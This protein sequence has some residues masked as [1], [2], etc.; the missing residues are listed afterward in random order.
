MFSKLPKIDLPKINL[1]P[2]LSGNGLSKLGLRPKLLASIT[3]MAGLSAIATVIAVLSFNSAE[4]QFTQF[5][6]NRVPALV[7]A[8]ELAI[9]SN[10]IT[11]SA[12]QLIGAKTEDTRITAFNTLESD[13]NALTQVV[14]ADSQTQEN[15][16]DMQKLQA[17]VGR[18]Q[19][20]LSDLDRLTRENLAKSENS[21]QMI[22]QLFKINNQM[23]FLLSPFSTRPIGNSR[24]T[25]L[26]LQ[27][28]QQQSST[29]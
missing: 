18:F 27:T 22:Q 9:K 29:G 11:I 2:V 19:S 23:S 24:V 10:E 16:A 4:Q 1:K 28:K 3:I 25:E 26:L 5:N 21:S 7:R 13:V 15:S 14:E 20:R 8:G 17:A 12:S 6:E